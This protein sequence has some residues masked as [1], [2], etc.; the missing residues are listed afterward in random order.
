N[1]LESDEGIYFTSAIRDI[2]ERKHVE[3]ALAR[4]AADLARSEEAYREQSKILR[5]ILDS[6][7]DGVIV[8]N[9]KGKFLLINPAADEVLGRT[10]SDAVTGT[11]TKRSGLFL[12]DG[13]TPYP[14][15]QL[16]LVRAIR[17]QAVDGAEMFVRHPQLP[18][19]KW[20]SANARP[21]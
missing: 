1:P 15:E 8:T 14:I 13:K 4:H 18:A 10:P 19:G 20:V 6:I 17:G 7:S 3:N 16:P 11:W 9:D 5:S 21:L 2:S 12:P